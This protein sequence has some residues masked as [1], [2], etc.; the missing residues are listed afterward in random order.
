M[1][2]P[3]GDVHARSGLGRVDPVPPLHPGEPDDG[4]GE[5]GH[6][7][8]D[9][10]YAP[11]LPPEDR[12]WRHPSEV[13]SGRAA[14]P[15]P[16]RTPDR[17][18]TTSLMLGSG[19]A[20]A[21]LAI[22]AVALLGGF[23]DR[24]VERQVAGSTA[25]VVEDDT[26]GPAAI[27]A[28]TAPSLAALRVERD[29]ERIEVSA[30][31]FRADGYLLADGPSV[32][33]ADDI[34]AVLQDGRTSSA[35]LVGVDDVTG[36]AVLQVD[37]DV[38]P[39]TFGDDAD[40]LAPGEPTVAVGASVARGWDAT[41]STGVVAGVNRRLQGRDG[42]TRHGMILVDRPFAP[43]SSGGALVDGDGTVVGMVSGGQATRAGTSFGVATPIDLVRHVAEQLVEHGHAQHVWLGLRGTD[44]DMDAAASMG[45]AGGALVDETVPDGPAHRAGIGPGDVIVAVDDEPTPT[46]SV[47]IATLRRHAPG[48]VVV[49]AVHRAGAAHTVRV[50]LDAKA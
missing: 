10:G 24:V 41:V 31:V 36:V 18:R 3:R 33:G 6:D 8:D 20:G 11:P 34:E 47:L 16:S 19:L 23:D 40:E 48:E 13:A 28:R 25:E 26:A 15:P 45:V 29:G 14:E 1:K 4:H 37:A 49:L 7:A 43:G 5:D 2:C 44:L 35:R 46:M 9:V 21:A 50:T 38:E 12:L 17:R 22:G 32:A 39:A 42:T 30:L 27:A